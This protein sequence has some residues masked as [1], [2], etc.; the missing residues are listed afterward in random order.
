MNRRHQSYCSDGATKFERSEFKA[1][2]TRGQAAWE[3]VAQLNFQVQPALLAFPTYFT[4][5][6]LHPQFTSTPHRS[7]LVMVKVREH[8]VLSKVWLGGVLKVWASIWSKRLHTV[9]SAN[10]K[11]DDGAPLVKKRTS[12]RHPCAFPVRVEFVAKLRVA[13]LA[14]DVTNGKTR[15]S[16][17]TF[18]HAEQGP[19]F[20]HSSLL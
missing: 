13:R 3:G 12:A 18:T 11:S 17:V 8:G 5:I 9:K 19:Y 4:P 20:F 6:T 16:A 10:A 1:L 15:L 14:V 7:Q 2:A